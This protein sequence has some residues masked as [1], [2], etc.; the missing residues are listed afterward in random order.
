MSFEDRA[1]CGWRIRSALPLPEL[2]VWSGS[3][4]APVDVAVEPGRVAP[5]S[6]RDP[7]LTIEADGT[8]RM[9]LP[10]TVRLLIENGRRIT[11]DVVGTEKAPA[12]RLF[13]LGLGMAILCHQRG[14]VPLH[15]AS[16]AVAGRTVT[17][18]GASGAGKST[19]AFALLRRGHTLLSDDLTVLAPGRPQ[20]LPAFARLRLW[21]DSLD[22]MGVSAAGLARSRDAL[23]KFDLEPDHGFDT[24][25]RPLGAVFLLKTGV[26]PALERVAPAAAVPLVSSH[27]AR[28]GV[29]RA[30][31]RRAEMFAAAAGVARAAP[32]Y[33]LVRSADFAH[34]DEMVRLVEAA[35]LAA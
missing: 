25:P 35:A 30:L 1:F 9:C 15:A 28:V 17:L 33:R 11:V 3:P 22:G 18:L 29:G 31:G 21:R 24:T 13:L 19:L 14:V 10:G 5:A 6:E 16:L 7:W 32:M 27:V 8:V 2:P 23:E 4:D 34:L 12:W 26:A 20:V